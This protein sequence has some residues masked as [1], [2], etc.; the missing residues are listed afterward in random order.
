[1]TD[2]NIVLPTVINPEGED[3]IVEI[4]DLDGVIHTELSYDAA[5]HRITG[6]P[7]QWGF[8]WQDII[9]KMKD[10]STQAGDETEVTIRIFYLVNPA[11]ETL[12]GFA[13]Y[14]TCLHCHDAELTSCIDCSPPNFYANG[15]CVDKCAE[16][17]VRIGDSCVPCDPLCKTCN[18]PTAT[19]CLSC[20]DDAFKIGETEC[21]SECP[22]GLFAE[23]I[24]KEC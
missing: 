18:G 17:T 11:L 19:E 13:C 14:Q 3:L 21:V 2:V 5:G 10:A 15:V 8:G 16:G 1:M 6:I 23:P 9:F 12:N 7:T 20:Q 22:S 24:S 4:T